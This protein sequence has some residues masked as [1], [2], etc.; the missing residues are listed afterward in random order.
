MLF[1]TSLFASTSTTGMPMAEGDEHEF[2]TPPTV[3]PLAE[4]VRKSKIAQS[5]FAT[6]EYVRIGRYQLLERVGAGGIGIVWGAWDPELERRVAIKFLKISSVPRERM[7]AEGQA[8]AKLSHPNVVPIY[9]VGVHDEQVYL[10]MEWVRGQTLRSFV[11]EEKRDQRE[12]I[13]LYRA[14]GE[15][16]AAA[17]AANL[18]HRDFKPDNAIRGED[19][20]V[21]VLDFGLA[22][23]EPIEVNTKMPTSSEVTRGVGTPR[24]MAPE[25]REGTTLTPATDQYAFCVSLREALTAHGQPVPRWVDAILVKGTSREPQHRF[26]S[27]HELLRALARDPRR[28]WRRR[29]AL[30]GVVVISGATFIMGNLRGVED[31]VEPCAGGDADVA[32]TWNAEAAQRMSAH[33]RSLGAYGAEEA[34]RLADDMTSYGKRWARA[35]KQTCLARERHVVTD[36]VY[37]R[38]L[39][40]VS[41]ARVSFDTAIDVLSNAQSSQLES[42]VETARGLPNVERCAFDA[43]ESSVVP[44]RREI[45]GLASQLAKEIERAHVLAKTDDPRAAA[46]TEI[47]VKRAEALGYV[48][49]IA[50]AYLAKGAAML[51]HQDGALALAAFERAEVAAIDAYDDPTFVEA[52]ARAV[53]AR[54]STDPNATAPV[55]HDY[56]EH[57]AMRS[58]AAGA[59]AR[60]LLFNNL[61]TARLAAGDRAGART[62]F[63][64]ALAETSVRNRDA[65]LIFAFA[66][67]ALVSDDP[68]Q[69]EKYLAAARTSMT[70]LLGANHRKTLAVGMMAAFHV[71]DPQRASREIGDLCDRFARYHGEVRD[72]IS[73]CRFEVGWLAEER[74]DIAAARAAFRDV[75]FEGSGL[76]AIAQAHLLAFDGKLAEAA[77]AARAVGEKFRDKTWARI[78]AAE[79]YRFAAACELKLGQ[80]QAALADAQASL[81]LLEQL[82]HLAAMGHYQRRLASTRALLTQ[83]H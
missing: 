71:L 79:A 11:A 46:A 51:T 53:Y 33:L 2:G 13:D 78:V 20:R 42:A 3:D 59:F 10:V 16:L 61:G 36:A 81:A 62:W 65:E 39:S 80:R 1:V 27:M 12:I 82:G 73:N 4:Q 35:Q 37:E 68:T 8:L 43:A 47:V 58:G 6:D 30:A 77:A 40:C 15:G 41:R 67:R 50:R 7:I 23:S 70:E 28:I 5:L 60:A 29:A 14:A 9:D 66:N 21:R 45:A 57:V 54:A 74:G 34:G 31:R 76:R 52:H 32:R 64:R 26:A 63:D 38:T 55:S 56:V 83:L 18:I 19:G 22:R 17:H 25:Q 24:Y 75:D 69:R 48:P 49:L 44:P 72:R